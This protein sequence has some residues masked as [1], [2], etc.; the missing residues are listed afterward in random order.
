MRKIVDNGLKVDFHIHSYY[1][2]TKDSASILNHSTI[3]DVPL[4]IQKI[5]DNGIQMC[6]IT[7]HDT[8]NYDLYSELKMYESDTNSSLIKVLP[9]V[10]FSVTF[11][12]NN[13]KKN[14]TL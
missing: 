11:N 8:F 3:N 5:N 2:T 1:S 4:L 7:D 12:R 6:A 10:E 13:V 14:Y 9:G